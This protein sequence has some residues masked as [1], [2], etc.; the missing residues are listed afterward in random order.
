M[1]KTCDVGLVDDR[2]V[3]TKA[4]AAFRGDSERRTVYLL[5]R[6]L[7]PAGKEGSRWVASRRRLLEH[8]DVLTA[9]R[10]VPPSDKPIG[11]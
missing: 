9:G 8:H 7:I 5:E 6:G 1:S 2:L 10:Q 11:D 3:G 4:I